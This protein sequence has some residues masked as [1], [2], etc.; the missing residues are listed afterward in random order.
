LGEGRCGEEK[1]EAEAGANRVEAG[2]HGR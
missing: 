2:A 1:N